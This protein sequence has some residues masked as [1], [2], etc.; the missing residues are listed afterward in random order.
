MWDMALSDERIAQVL[1]LWGMGGI[2]KTTLASAVYNE[3]LPEWETACFLKSVRTKSARPDQRVAMQLE[4][5]G[6]LTGDA[7]RQ[8]N[9][10]DQGA[11]RTQYAF[12]QQLSR[13]FEVHTQ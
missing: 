6:A 8:L 11:K 2:G 12:R 4:L 5:L 3:L 10:E 1:G 9:C 13:L 7:V